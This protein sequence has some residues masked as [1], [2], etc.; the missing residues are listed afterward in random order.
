MIADDHR[1]PFRA[2][3]MPKNLRALAIKSFAK[4]YVWRD[5]MRPPITF[6]MSIRLDVAHDG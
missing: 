2:A 5:W 3:Q 1:A 4:F 6:H